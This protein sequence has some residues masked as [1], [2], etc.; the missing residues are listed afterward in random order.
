MTQQR[1]RIRIKAFDHA[2]IDNACS[3]IIET[4]EENG[5]MFVGPIPLPTKKEI[6]TVN[7]STFV[8]GKSKD[9]FEMRTHNRLIDILQYTPKTIEALSTIDLPAGVD[10]EIKMLTEV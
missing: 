6:F 7:R 9:Q 3:L 1:I 10:L 8:H 5:S 4:I 2:I